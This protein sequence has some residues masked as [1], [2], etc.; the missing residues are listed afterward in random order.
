MAN[1]SKREQIIEA[2]KTN[3]EDIPAITEVTRVRP[4]FTD[5][6]NFAGTQLPLVSLVG[7]LPK[8]VPHK[9]GRRTG[10]H[11]KFISD[12]DV[13]LYCYAL[14]NV[15]P[16]SKVSDLADDLWVKIHSDPT[17]I[18]TAYPEGLALQ[19][20]ILPEIQVGIWDPYVVFKMTCT[21]QYVHDTGGI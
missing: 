10:L 5:L 18:T 9:A 16:D 21:Y 20:I 4:N 12:L 11:D 7:K 6:E 1:N 8:P 13:E 2:L 17:L 19:V 15:N 14:E 3:V